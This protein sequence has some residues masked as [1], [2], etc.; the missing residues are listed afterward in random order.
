[1]WWCMSHCWREA[2]GALLWSTWKSLDTLTGTLCSCRSLQWQLLLQRLPASQGGSD[3]IFLNT[4]GFSPALFLTVWITSVSPPSQGSLLSGIS[5]L[6]QLQDVIVSMQ[7]GWERPLQ[8]R[9]P[10][11]PMGQIF[12][13]QDVPCVLVLA[14]TDSIFFIVADVG[15]CFGIVLETG[16]VTQGCLHYWWAGLV[17]CQVFYCISFHATSRRLRLHKERT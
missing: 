3:G 4:M 15:L 9:L 2:M 8:C 17:H 11:G 7:L 10:T 16:V 12:L 6:L 5:M 14:G 13:G 1:M